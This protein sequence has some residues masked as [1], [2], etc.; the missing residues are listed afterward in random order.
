MLSVRPWTSTVRVRDLLEL[1]KFCAT[2]CHHSVGFPV[3]LRVC[4]CSHTLVVLFLEA[5]LVLWLP[6]LCSLLPPRHLGV[7]AERLWSRRIPTCCWFLPLALAPYKVSSLSDL[8]FCPDAFM[9]SL[10]VIGSCTR[11]FG[12]ACVGGCREAGRTAMFSAVWL[13]RGA[14]CLLELCGGRSSSF[15]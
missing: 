15:V 10:V 1:S 3:Y 8:H 9:M 5:G 11:F 14:S 4:P 12:T 6:A 2:R 13:I 7:H